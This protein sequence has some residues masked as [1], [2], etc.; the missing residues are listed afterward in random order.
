VKRERGADSRD[1][2][3]FVA[4]EIYRSER[5]SICGRDARDCCRQHHRHCDTDPQLHALLLENV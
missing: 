1:I 2:E 4:K 3:S 5:P